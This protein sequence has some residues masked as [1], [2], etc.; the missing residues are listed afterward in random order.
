MHSDDR[1][2]QIFEYN[3]SGITIQQQKLSISWN[4]HKLRV[5]RVG[6][7]TG[8]TDCFEEAFMFV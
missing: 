3:K 2:I 5:G 6:I 8:A 1:M 7:I 4:F